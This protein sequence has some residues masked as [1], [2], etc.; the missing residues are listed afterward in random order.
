MGKGRQKA[1]PAPACRSRAEIH[2]GS[3]RKGSLCPGFIPPA[4]FP[5]ARSLV[6]ALWMGGLQAQELSGCHV[7]RAELSEVFRASC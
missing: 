6:L 5:L 2:P 7:P 4:L 3:A 1:T